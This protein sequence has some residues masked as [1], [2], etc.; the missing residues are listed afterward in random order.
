MM[1]HLHMHEGMGG[2]HHFVIIVRSNDPR[3]PEKELSLK[4]DFGDY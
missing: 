2:P 3:E 1:V 4:A